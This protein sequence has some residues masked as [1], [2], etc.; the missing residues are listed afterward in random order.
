MACDLWLR[1]HAGLRPEPREPWASSHEPLFADAEALDQVRVAVGVL[2]LQVI[3][4]AAALADQFQEAAPGVVV[5]RVGLE[6]LG[7][8]ADALAEE[9][10]LHFGRAG[11]AVVGLVAVDDFGLTVLGEHVSSFHERPRPS[12]RY[13][14]HQA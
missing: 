8:I 6:M 5:F 3:Q 2:A 10:D 13:A 11:V 1:A 4:Q 7:E 12:E 9:R 14:P